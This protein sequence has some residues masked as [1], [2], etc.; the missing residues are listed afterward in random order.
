MHADALF[1]I[2]ASLA[3]FRE[4]EGVV[5]VDRVERKKRAYIAR[6]RYTTA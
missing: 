6:R 5:S 2:A 4:V 1:Q 3:A